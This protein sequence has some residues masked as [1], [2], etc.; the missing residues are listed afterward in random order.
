MDRAEVIKGTLT[1][2]SVTKKDRGTYIFR[3]ENIL[4]SAAGTF[5]LMVYPRLRFFKLDPQKK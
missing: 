2:Y 5:H 4:G 3:A 1:I